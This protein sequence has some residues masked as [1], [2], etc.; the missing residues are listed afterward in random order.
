M[1]AE[2]GL[3]K[4]FLDI[5]NALDA[6]GAEYIVVGA[7][8]MALHGVPRAT[9]DIDILVRP[10]SDNAS[11]VLDALGAF[12][13][14]T[15]AHGLTRNDLEIP[16]NVY[17]IGLPPRRIDFLT[18]ISGLSFEEAW[19]SRELVQVGEILVPFLGREALAR[20]KRASGRE[21]DLL[22]LRLLGGE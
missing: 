8:A 14:P 2:A 9:G 18:S 10:N 13:A 6:A 5:L 16:G 22:D 21:K 1:S 4:D 20:N 12:G 19:E 17:Q 7:H 11:R 15:K 3:N